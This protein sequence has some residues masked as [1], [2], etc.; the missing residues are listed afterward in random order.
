MKFMFMRKVAS[1]F[2]NDPSHRLR[3]TALLV[4]IVLGLISA[5]AVAGIIIWVYNSERFY[6]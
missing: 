3:V 1:L 2:F 4:S 6:R 5:A